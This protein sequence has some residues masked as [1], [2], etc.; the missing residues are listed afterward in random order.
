VSRQGQSADMPPDIPR[1]R[2]KDRNAKSG[3][4]RILPVSAIKPSP[5]NERL[6][7][8]VSLDDPSLHDLAQS[9]REIGFSVPITISRDRVILSGHRRFAAA[10]LVGL[11]EAP[12]IVEKIDR[13]STSGGLNPQF[14]NRLEMLVARTN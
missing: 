6:Y 5:E 12:C 1:H 14:V 4:V 10:Q 2:R 3:H 8:P 13:V 9:I 7:R 11:N